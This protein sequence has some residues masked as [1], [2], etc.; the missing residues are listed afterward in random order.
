LLPVILTVPIFYI[1]SVQFCLLDVFIHLCYNVSV[2]YYSLV[3]MFVILMPLHCD[4]VEIFVTIWEYFNE[5]LCLS[6][7]TVCSQSD[8]YLFVWLRQCT[9]TP[10]KSRN[11]HHDHDT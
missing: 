6:V 7:T 11:I 10:T 5:I 4:P 3:Y 9:A 8:R 1:S 2:R